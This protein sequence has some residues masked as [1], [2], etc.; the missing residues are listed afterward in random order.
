MFIVKQGGFPPI[1]IRD[2]C[3]SS[4]FFLVI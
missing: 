2:C 4:G 3:S 1:L